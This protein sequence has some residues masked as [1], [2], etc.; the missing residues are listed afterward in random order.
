MLGTR[1]SNIAL[2]M[3]AL[4]LTGSPAAA[5]WT[6]FAATAPSFLVYMPAGAL[7]DRWHP[8][9]VMLISEFGRGL[10]IATVV[11]ALLLA[12]LSLPLLIGAA[13]VEEILE[14]F[15]TLAE[16]R[17][18]SSLTGP[19][20]AS[21]ALVRLE[22]RTHVVVLAGRPLGG[23]LFTVAPTLPFVA[24]MLSFVISVGALIGLKSRQAARLP[25]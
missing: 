23:L 10:A 4:Y 3:L 17:Y 15:S 1:M 22:A 8:R 20:Q 7:V 24:D 5:G 16:R 6:A 9:R 14:V 21:S 11:M 13:V 2:P 12:R 18:V 25:A 19:E